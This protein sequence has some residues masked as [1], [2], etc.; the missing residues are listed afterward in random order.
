M[1]NNDWNIVLKDILNSNYFLE[2]NN[3][4]NAE[5]QEKIIYPDKNLIFNALN[6]TP[7]KDVKVVILGQDPYHGENEAHGLAF[8]ILEGKL[9]PSLKNIFKELENDLKIVNTNGNLTKWAKEG[10]LLLNTCL[11]VVKDTPFSH[12]KLGWNIFVN[13]IISAIN[14]KDTPVVFI[15]WGNSAK[16]KKV[17]ITNDKHLVIESTHP[18][19]FSARHG[20]FN[21]KPF[22]KTNKF[23]KEKNMQSIDWQL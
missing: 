6:L 21:S 16:E 12:K 23:L 11:T 10:V 13:E 14:K 22:S 18:S 4:I 1:I 20:F 9:P 2:L 17:L 19:P 15:L 5:Y 7:Y 8:S 3:K